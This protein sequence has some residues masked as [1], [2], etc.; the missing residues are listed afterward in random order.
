LSRY[1][2]QIQS[3][4]VVLAVTAP[5]VAPGDLVTPVPEPSLN[6]TLAALLSKV[7]VRYVATGQ[8]NSSVP[9]LASIGPIMPS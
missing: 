1:L 5:S 7:D 9:E 4:E 8:Y 6:S 2:V 3:T